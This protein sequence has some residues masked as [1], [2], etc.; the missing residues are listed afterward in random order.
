MLWDGKN[1]ITRLIYCLVAFCLFCVTYASRVPKVAVCIGGQTTRMQPPLM[2]EG[3]L[4][5]N[6]GH[7]LFDFYYNLQVPPEGQEH[8][9]YNTDSH[10]T[11]EP[12]NYGKMNRTELVINLGKV[13]T[14][15]Y[16][17]IVNISF[18]Q[19]VPMDVVEHSMGHPLNLFEVEAM[20]S[21]KVQATILNMYLH[22]M[23]CINQIVEHERQQG[24]VYD[25]VISTR[26]DVYF[27]RPMNLTYVISVLDQEV[28]HSTAHSERKC[29]MVMK[30]CANFFGFNQRMF[31]YDR[32]TA[33]ITL[34]N[35]W[36]HF[37]YLLHQNATL[38]NTEVFEKNMAEHY[39]LRSCPIFIDH[40]AVTAVRP[41]RDDIFCYPFWEI[42]KC[43]PTN[44]ARAIGRHRCD[45]YLS[46]AKKVNT[47]SS[48]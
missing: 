21:A 2:V 6:E 35:R 3:L 1:W 16:S 31:V 18:H 34:S 43:L 46:I 22:Q 12:S 48:S 32:K 45:R 26:E 20:K 42:F 14:T 39:R 36:N 13:M 47:T 5:P 7:F 27:M 10:I 23:R 11:F 8:I 15:N 38:I 19:L 37:R 28:D 9:I 40:F 4:Q 44:S 29:H 33:N 25:Y 17:A 41:I 30:E 24:F